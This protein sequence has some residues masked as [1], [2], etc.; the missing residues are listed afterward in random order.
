MDRDLRDK[1]KRKRR[2]VMR[3]EK[4][5]YSL[6]MLLLI[7]SSGFVWLAFDTPYAGAQ[8]GDNAVWGSSSRV[9]SS[10]FI[11]ASAFCAT[12][13]ACSSSV[14]DFCNVVNQALHI[15]PSAGGVVDARG[16]NPANTKSTS[17]TG[18]PFNGTFAINTPSTVLLPAGT[19]P[20]GKT[21]ILPNGTKLIGQ[22]AGSPLSTGLDSVTTIQA[23]ATFSTTFMIQMGPNS[24]NS[25]L[26][27]CTALPGGFCTGISVENLALQG[28]TNGANVSGIINGQAQDM[29]YVRRVSMD[30][31]GGTGLKVWSNAK[32]SGP[33]SEITF[34]AGSVGASTTICAQIVATSTLNVPTRGI[35]GVTC[36]SNGTSNVGIQVD[37]SNNSIEDVQLQGFEDGIVVGSTA[38]VSATSN[39]LLNVTGSSSMTS[40]V[41]LENVGTVEDVGIIGVSG[42]GS[43]FSIKDD[44][45]SS[46]TLSLSDPYIAMYVLGESTPI[47]SSNVGYSRF[48]TSTN[49]SAV[50]WGVGSTAPLG[51]C[52]N[53]GSF[54]SY[55]PA[56]NNGN[57]YLCTGTWILF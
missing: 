3:S 9:A 14:D 20:L 26:T 11:D 56:S 45:S 57:L 19:I 8:L 5:F 4:R 23:K 25:P 7:A 28:G 54:F 38:G 51:S 36:I 16:V 52:N 33:Y 27:A 15:L 22:G 55:S 21:W 34:D 50:T 30:Q 31:I 24:N 41:H 2:N 18:T 49:S 46:P 35:H 32:N 40:V 53:R 43:A 47:G 17:C 6:P 44:V 1:E 12:A 39:V 37:S 10:A 48:T 13:G 29:S 42:N